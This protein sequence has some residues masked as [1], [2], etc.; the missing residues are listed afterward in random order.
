MKNIIKNIIKKIIKEDLQSNANI[1]IRQITKDDLKQII[2]RLGEV[3]NK[4]GLSSQQIWGMMQHSDFNKSVVATIDDKIAGFYFFSN[5]QIPETRNEIYYELKNLNGIEGVA[6]GIFEEYKNL[7]IGKKLIEYTKSIPGVDYIWGYQLKSLKNIDDWLKRRKIYAENDYMYVTYQLFNKSLSENFKKRLN[8]I[9]ALDAYNQYYKGLVDKENQEK[10]LSTYNT[11]VRL[12]PTFI[13]N[14]EN[15]G[16]YTKWIFR[17]DNLAWILNNIKTRRGEDLYKIKES[18]TLFEK[19]KRTNNLPIDKKDINKFN[20][21]TLFN[22]TFELQNQNLQSNTEKEKEIKEGAKKVFENDEWAIIVPDTE[23]AACYYGKGTKWCTAGNTN[24]QFDYYNR[25]GTLYILINKQDPSEKFQFHFESSQF[26]DVMDR[27]IN[28]S[29]FFNDNS[30]VYDFFSNVIPNLEFTMCE[31]ALENGNTESFDDFYT[32]N[33][34]DEQKRR[35]IVAAFE[36]DN[37]SDNYYT[38]SH[39]LNYLNYEGMEEDFKRDFIYGFETSIENRYDDENYDALMFL[40]YLGGIN[41]N[42]YDDIFR[43]VDFKKPNEIQKIFEIVKEFEGGSYLLN[44]YIKENEININ[45]DLLDTLEYLK[46]KFFYSDRNNMFSSNIATVIINEITD[47]Q[48]GL[49]KIDFIPKD[50]E[51]G[52]IRDKAATGVV[53]YKNLIKYLTIPQIPLNESRK[54]LIPE[55]VTKTKIICDNCGWSWNIKD[56][57]KDLY[58]CHKCGHDNN[59]NILN[60]RCWKGYTQKGMKTMFGKRYPNCVKSKK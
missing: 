11:I 6:L 9:K 50:A 22:L 42:N 1:V 35:L 57:G 4:T 24:N 37:N 29:D 8:E 17:K 30:E 44:K 14:T 18:L 38:V 60:E 56:G 3:F 7:G 25:Q 39:V 58:V 49:I 55:K 36:G 47:Y 15:L 43:Q 41:E 34:T 31:K 53:N 45:H 21:D 54:K 46:S 19:A 51:G 28:I 2:P 52:Q 13:E 32:R 5:E 26:M 20:I 48:K 59:P 12:D 23:E 27:Q 40:N 10:D 16:Q 33:F